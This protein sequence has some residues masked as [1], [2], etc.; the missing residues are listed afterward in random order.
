M[1]SNNE[2]WKKQIEDMLKK[3]IHFLESEK[4]KKAQEEFKKNN[5]ELLEIK[6]NIENMSKNEIAQVILSITRQLDEKDKYIESIKPDLECLDKIKNE[7][8][9]KF[10]L[11]DDY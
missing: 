2:F 7:I 6:N 8:I 10:N 1:S 5:K 11:E 3:E 9:E 4:Q